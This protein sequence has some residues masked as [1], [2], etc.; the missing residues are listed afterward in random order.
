MAYLGI[1]MLWL[2]FALGRAL[3]EYNEV[4][5]LYNIWHILYRT[6]FCCAQKNML[7]DD[8]MELKPVLHHWLFGHVLWISPTKGQLYEVW[9]LSLLLASSSR[10]TVSQ[11]TGNLRRHD[12]KES[13]R[14][15]KA[16]AVKFRCYICH[17]F[18]QA[19]EHSVKLSVIDDMQFSFMLGCSNTRHLDVPCWGLFASSALRS[20]C[21]A[22][23]KHV[24]QCQR[25]SACWLQPEW[26]VQCESSPV[27]HSP[28]SPSK[29]FSHM[30]KPV[31]RWPGHHHWIA[32][33]TAREADCREDQHGRN[34]ASGKHGQTKVLIS[35]PGLDELQ[36]SGKGP[37]GGRQHKLHFLWWM[38]QLDPP[39]I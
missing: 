28:G 30:Q 27:Y 1:S 17:W 2:A 39:E 36:K 13:V 22:H 31:C 26:R 11:V 19:V 25:R 9:M 32:E 5:V 4:R 35:G 37:C 7:Y 24:W 18:D 6:Q 10:S 21:A 23:T 16:N 15:Q 34:G 29:S 33:G 20:G 14:R 12:A 8:L 38:F 3:G